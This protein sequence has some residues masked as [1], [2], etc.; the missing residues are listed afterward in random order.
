[1]IALTPIAESVILKKQIRRTVGV[2][3]DSDHN[4]KEKV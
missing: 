4:F 1:M 2:A 3:S